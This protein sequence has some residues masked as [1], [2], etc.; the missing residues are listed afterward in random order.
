LTPKGNK[1]KLAYAVNWGKKI[2]RANRKWRWLFD[3]QQLTKIRRQ[4]TKNYDGPVYNL[5][6]EGLHDYVVEGVVVHNCFDTTFVG[7]YASPMLIYLQM[8]PSPKAPQPT[9]TGEMHFQETTARTTWFPPL[10]PKDLIVEGENIRWR[11]EQ[12]TPTEK[13]RALVRQELRVRQYAR[14]DIKYKVPVELDLMLQMSPE[15]ELRRPM[16]LQDEN[17]TSIEKVVVP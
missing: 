9:D 8:D 13:L 2:N 10:K 12:V 11:V 16:D 4:T 7:G 1:R 15:R 14:D 5:E 17:E 3:E 6:V